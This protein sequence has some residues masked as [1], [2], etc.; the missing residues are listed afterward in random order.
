M[1][2]FSISASVNSGSSLVTLLL[3]FGQSYFALHDNAGKSR[4]YVYI[5]ERRTIFDGLSAAKRAKILSMAR[6]Y[7]ASEN[8]TSLK[9]LF[10]NDVV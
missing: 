9:K 1:L 3:S 4:G 6:A 7:L 2:G 10:N 5:F 8:Y